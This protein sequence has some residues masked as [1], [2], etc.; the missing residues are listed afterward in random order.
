MSAIA[1]KLPGTE[2]DDSKPILFWSAI[3]VQQQPIKQS[4]KAKQTKQSKAKKLW[5]WLLWC[6]EER[7]IC[8]RHTF[9]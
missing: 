9:C 4:S 3:H 8:W 7:G 1:A 5:L 6:V 2:S